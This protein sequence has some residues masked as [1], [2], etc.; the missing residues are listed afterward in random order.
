MLCFAYGYLEEKGSC[1]KRA[2]FAYTFFLKGVEM[3]GIN[4]EGL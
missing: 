1:A 3:G 2:G 4:G